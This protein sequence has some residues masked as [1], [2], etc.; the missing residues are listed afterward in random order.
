M[1]HKLVPLS[2]TT[3]YPVYVFS[4]LIQVTN[5][6]NQPEEPAKRGHRAARTSLTITNSLQRQYESGLGIVMTSLYTKYAGISLS[7]SV[8]ATTTCSTSA[9]SH[10]VS[11]DHQQILNVTRI[12]VASNQLYNYTYSTVSV[13]TIAAENEW[14]KN[15]EHLHLCHL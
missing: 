10:D 13:T 9:G 12:Q 1:V 11:A 15:V 4:Q 5:T 2:M 3:A 8:S 6:L 7:V 14:A